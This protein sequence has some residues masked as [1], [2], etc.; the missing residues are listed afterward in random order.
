L[1]IFS[2]ACSIF[3]GF[4][5]F[6]QELSRFLK[7]LYKTFDVILAF[8]NLLILIAVALDYVLEHLSDTYPDDF[9]CN[10]LDD[11]Q[12][13]NEFD[14][15]YISFLLLYIAFFIIDQVLWLA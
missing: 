2:F 7:K 15:P 14:I 8:E 6:L 9:E 13:S 3:C 1:C 11:K 4:E 10:N 12:L 5:L